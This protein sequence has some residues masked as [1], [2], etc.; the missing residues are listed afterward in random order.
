MLSCINNGC[1]MLLVDGGLHYWLSCFS[2][3]HVC[4]Y[5]TG[6]N[7]CSWAP[8]LAQLCCRCQGSYL[9]AAGMDARH[10]AGDTRSEWRETLCLV[11]LILQKTLITQR[12]GVTHSLCTSAIAPTCF[13]FFFKSAAAVGN[14]VSTLTMKAFEKQLRPARRDGGTEEERDVW[15][16]TSGVWLT[17]WPSCMSC[18]F[19]EPLSQKRSRRRA[20]FVLQ[21]ATLSSNLY[22]LGWC[23]HLHIGRSMPVKGRISP[24]RNTYFTEQP[25]TFL[26]GLLTPILSA[27]SVLLLGTLGGEVLQ[28]A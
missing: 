16:V 23:M 1:W 9:G 6:L 17:C 7:P 21:H 24:T 19:L 15:S 26:P 13:F 8:E 18:P 14:D 4:F 22:N 10:N 5:L 12:S 20:Q 2:W 27:N 28:E 3:S 11:S 25:R